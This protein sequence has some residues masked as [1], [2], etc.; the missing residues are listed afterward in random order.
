[1]K[2]DDRAEQG[3]E[4]QRLEGSH[5]QTPKTLNLAFVYLPFTSTIVTEDA[6]NKMLP[7]L[8]RWLRSLNSKINI[9]YRLNSLFKHVE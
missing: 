4:Q 8:K 2:V 7:G 1:M 5:T 9:Y 6:A 3:L